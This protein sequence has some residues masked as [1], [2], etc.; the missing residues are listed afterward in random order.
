MKRRYDSYPCFREFA[1]LDQNVNFDDKVVL[2][3][4]CGLGI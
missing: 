1:G 3:Y 4:G 2:D